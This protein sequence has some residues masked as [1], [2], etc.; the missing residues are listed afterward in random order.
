MGAEA[1]ITARV[2]SKTRDIVTVAFQLWAQP[3]MRDWTMGYHF[4]LAYAVVP[5]GLRLPQV[6][7]GQAVIPFGLLADYDTHTQIVQTP[8]AKTLSQR[9]DLGAGLQG[10]IAQTAYALWVSNGHGPAPTGQ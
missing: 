9:I 3:D 5:L 6:K 7:V 2:S 1:E 10:S 8:F 4:G